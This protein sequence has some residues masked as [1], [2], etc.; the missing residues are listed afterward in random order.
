M[1][2]FSLK[3][4]NVNL[5]IKSKSFELTSAVN[6]STFKN[7]SPFPYRKRIIPELNLLSWT[8]FF[9]SDCRCRIKENSAQCS[10]IATQHVNTEFS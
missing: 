3:K 2:H 5:P 9:Y 1:D 6:W 7:I 10:I 4:F 8:L